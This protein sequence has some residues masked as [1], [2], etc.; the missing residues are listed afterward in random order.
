MHSQNKKLPLTIYEVNWYTFPVLQQ[1]YF[2]HMLRSAQSDRHKE[3]QI[4]D[5]APLNLE[6]AA[7]ITEKIYQMFM[8]ML[9]WIK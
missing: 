1:R 8:M 7:H 3:F 9:R 2:L 4:M 6:T 5:Q